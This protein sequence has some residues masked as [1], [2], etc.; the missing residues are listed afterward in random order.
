LPVKLT[1]KE[2]VCV[3]FPSYENDTELIKSTKSHKAMHAIF[4]LAEKNAF[5]KEV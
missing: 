3:H 1:S 2:P 4:G 5:I